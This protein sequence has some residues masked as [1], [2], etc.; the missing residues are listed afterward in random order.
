MLAVIAVAVLVFPAAGKTEFAYGNHKD[1]TLDLYPAPGATPAP[2]MI[3]VHGGGWSK[4]DKARVG[5]KASYFNAKGWN[6]VS[7]N[8]RLHPDGAP[9]KNVEDV[10]KAIA[11][12]HDHAAERGGDPDKLFI[13]G[14]SAGAYL[15]ALVAT[16]MRPMLKA[17][18]DLSVIKGV[19]ALDTQAYDIPELM[20]DSRGG[21]ALY[22]TI[23]SADPASWKDASPIKHVG[24][25]KSVPPFLIC[26]SRG[27]GQTVNPGRLKQADNF[28]AA[29][30]VFG[31]PAELIDA[32]DRDH[33][34]IN[35]RFGALDDVKVTGATERFLAG[36]IREID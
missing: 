27:M 13:M 19:V 8:Y 18:K 28:A 30:S 11:W 1:Q 3:Y 7:A 32:S 21:G 22:E 36:I 24:S 12:V 25:G 6:F 23:F 29:L 17:G 15:V 10:A 4:G 35:Q 16:D 20:K 2:T 31:I 34:E 14:H 33:A 5:M 26:F 9:P